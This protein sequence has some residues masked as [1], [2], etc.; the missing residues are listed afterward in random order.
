MLNQMRVMQTIDLTMVNDMLR[1]VYANEIVPVK[2]K[3][4]LR[5]YL[6]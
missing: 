1:N 6:S 4:H 3:D 5:R 2:E